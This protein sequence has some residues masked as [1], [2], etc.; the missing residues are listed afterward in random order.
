MNYQTSHPG[1]VIDAEYVEVIPA[2]RGIGTSLQSWRASMMVGRVVEE[3]MVLDTRDQ[4]LAMLAKAGM[5]HT[6]ALSVMEAQ[7]SRMTPQAA[8]RY[9]AIVNA[10][11]Q[12]AV[13]TIRRW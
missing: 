9:Q 6:A 11:A 13:N 12:Q 7:F 8:E 2:Q 3:A 10:Y 4:C 5:E 1:E